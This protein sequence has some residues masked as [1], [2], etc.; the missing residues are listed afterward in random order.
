MEA[1]DRVSGRE[2]V[3]ERMMKS[4]KNGL[5][6]LLRRDPRGYLKGQNINLDFH[7]IPHYGEESELEENW[8]ATKGKNMKSILS[9]FAQDLDTTF[10]CFSNGEI[11]REDMNDEI[12]EFVKFYKESIGIKPERLIFDSKLTTYENLNSLNEEGIL[13]IT[14]KRRGK[15]FLKEVAKIKKWKKVKID[16]L[17][18]KYKNLQVS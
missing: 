4:I 2:A 10:L 11:R 6:S 5:C 1:L 12:M 8:V 18:R 13:F 15:N 17:G 14:L 7:V 9:F 16:K 3:A